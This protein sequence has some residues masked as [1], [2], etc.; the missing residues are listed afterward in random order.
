MKKR[1][2]NKNKLKIKLLALF[3]SLLFVV[4]AG[5][6]IGDSLAAENN[7]EVDKKITS[8]DETKGICNIELSVKGELM[9]SEKKADIVLCIDSS[10]SMNNIFESQS[11]LMKVKSAVEDFSK[12]F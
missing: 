3:V 6:F 11:K 2:F 8:F 12:M 5:K 4:G 7:I 1:D 10:G 9:E